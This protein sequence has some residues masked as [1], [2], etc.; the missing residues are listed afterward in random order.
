MSD[1]GPRDPSDL[2]HAGDCALCGQPVY[3][4]EEYAPVWTETPPDRR[5]ARIRAEG[6]Q[7]KDRGRPG[8]IQDV[9]VYG[10]EAAEWIALL[11]ALKSESR[12]EVKMA[13]RVMETH[14]VGQKEP[15][16][17][18]PITSKWDAHGNDDK[19]G[20]TVRVNPPDEAP[21]ADEILHRECHDA[22]FGDDS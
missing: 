15:V 14:A 18:D 13:P 22:L 1:A 10:H 11:K 2:D 20:A 19:A 12:I 3:E 6:Q 7:K 21:E 8:A 4:H 17:I 5:S 9:T 16:H